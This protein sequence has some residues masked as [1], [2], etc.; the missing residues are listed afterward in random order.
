MIKKVNK[1]VLIGKV[2]SNKMDKTITVLVEWLK[3]HPIYKKYLR[4]SKKF[5]A[6]DEKSICKIGDKVKIIECRP[7]SRHKHFRLVEVLEKT[8]GN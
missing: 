1:K 5:K 7:I 2:V 3:L 8:R 6:H 4:K